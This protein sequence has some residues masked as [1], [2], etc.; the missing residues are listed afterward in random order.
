MT[1]ALQWTPLLVAVAIGVT[2]GNHIR[3][4]RYRRAADIGYRDGFP[5]GRL[6]RGAGSR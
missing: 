6:T 3:A 2:I 4:A 1:A 5:T